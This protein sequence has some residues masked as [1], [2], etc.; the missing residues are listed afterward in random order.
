MGS[1]GWLRRQDSRRLTALLKTSAAS[2]TS[3]RIPDADMSNL[4]TNRDTASW[5]EHIASESDPA[6]R[7]RWHNDGL[8]IARRRCGIDKPFRMGTRHG[9]GLV[10]LCSER[11]ATADRCPWFQFPVQCGRVGVLLRPYARANRPGDAAR[12][13]RPAGQPLGRA[14]PGAPLLAAGTG[15]P[16]DART[17]LDPL[18]AYLGSACR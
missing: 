8:P 17:V 14:R 3:L 15:D 1:S 9:A 13:K 12:A 4:S 10:V 11:T 16:S 6:Q 5:V 2:A 7:K 18:C